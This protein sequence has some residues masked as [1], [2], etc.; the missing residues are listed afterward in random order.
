M[1]K[2][3]IAVFMP[4]LLVKSCYRNVL[5][6]PGIYSIRVTSKSTDDSLSEILYH[7]SFVAFLFNFFNSLTTNFVSVWQYNNTSPVCLLSLIGLKGF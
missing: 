4:C 3:K 1:K 6:V 7:S 5:H 2:V